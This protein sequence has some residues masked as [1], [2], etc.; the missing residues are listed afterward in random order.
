MGVQL[1]SGL[2]R[3]TGDRVV[4]GLNPSVAT[5]L[6]NIGHSVYPALSVSFGEDTKSCR[7]LLS[8]VYARGSKRSTSLRWKCVTY[9]AHSNL[10]KDNSL[11]YSC[12]SPKMGGLAHKVE[13]QRKSSQYLEF[14]CRLCSRLSSC[15]YRVSARHGPCWSVTTWAATSLS[16]R[17]S[18]RYC[19]RWT[20]RA[21]C[22]LYTTSPCHTS[23]PWYGSSRDLRATS[24][25]PWCSGRQTA[26]LASTSCSRTST[27]VASSPRTVGCTAS[28]GRTSCGRSP[29]I[30][31][32]ETCFAPRRTWGW[33]GAR[34]GRWW[35]PRLAMQSSTRS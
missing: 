16:R 28:P 20:R 22:C 26:T 31:T 33:C 25:L 9:V 14:E 32:S 1:P 35:A 10:E 4:L 8:G 21:A 15:R 11:N 6:W 2:E 17:D 12:V 3:W 30:R 13:I 7:S 27:R 24:T 5:S 29:S 19:G 18:S 34:R 23:S